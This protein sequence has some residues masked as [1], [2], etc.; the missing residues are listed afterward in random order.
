[1]IGAAL[2]FLAI[3]IADLVAGGLGGNPR[4]GRS[5]NAG[6]AAAIVV[7]VPAAWLTDSA[8][9]FSLALLFNGAGTAT[10]LRL[11]TPSPPTTGRAWMALGALT[12]T[13]AIA[14]GMSGL[15]AN[16]SMPLVGG[17]LAGLPFPA[18]AEISASRHFLL[19]ALLVFLGATANGVVRTVLAAA[20]TETKRS[21]QRLRGGRVIGIV[22]RWIIFGLVL[23]G[24]PTAAALVVSAKSILRF[25]ELSKVAIE[26]SPAPGKSGPALTQEVDY[27]T[28]YFLLGSLVSWLLAIGPAI[29]AAV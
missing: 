5:A 6:V 26:Q 1:M 3:G 4:S 10:W 27:V 19:I 9:V 23:S 11:R 12:A 25:P 18:L 24:E 16:P 21:E 29:L 8:W 17:W 13:I 14:I 15:W 22:E 28:E 7:T 2:S 20:G